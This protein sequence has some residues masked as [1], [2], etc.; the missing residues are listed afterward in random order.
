MPYQLA[1]VCRGLDI[2][3]IGEGDEDTAALAIA[4]NI[5]LDQVIQHLHIACPGSER[6][7]SQSSLAPD[8]NAAAFTTLNA[9]KG[10]FVQEY[11][12][13]RDEPVVAQAHVGDTGAFARGE[14]A[15]NVVVSYLVIG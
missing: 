12:V 1:G 13:A 6:R 15:A 10:A 9:V 3:T 11:L 5:T 14:V 2:K 7:R 8:D 4:C